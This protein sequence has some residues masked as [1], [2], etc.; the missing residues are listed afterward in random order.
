MTRPR[1]PARV[2]E[3]VERP[4]LYDPAV[5]TDPLQVVFVEL[6]CLCGALW[7]QRDPVSWV[8]PQV[9]DFLTRHGGNGHGPASKKDCID[10]REVVREAALVAQRRGVEYERKIY[11]NID[12]QCTAERA[13]P[14][15]PDVTPE[16]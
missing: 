16:G 11:P 2:T 14:V 5:H 9:R 7:R 1:G 12:D 4:P 13:W 3:P 15:M 10:Q 8:E 6:Y